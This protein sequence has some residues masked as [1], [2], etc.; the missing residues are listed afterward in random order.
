MEEMELQRFRQCEAELPNYNST[1]RSEPQFHSHAN[2][3]DNN[4]LWEDTLAEK[5]LICQREA[6]QEEVEAAVREL[7]ME[8]AESGLRG[9]EARLHSY[10]SSHAVRYN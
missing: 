5:D 6:F 8:D 2:D 7:R 9:L 10:H 3:D 1:A 4:T